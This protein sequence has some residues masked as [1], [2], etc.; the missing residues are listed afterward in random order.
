MK[1]KTIGVLLITLVMIISIG[2]ISAADT[3]DTLLGAVSDTNNPLLVEASDTNIATTSVALDYEDNATSLESDAGS[4][5]EINVNDNQDEISNQKVG[6]SSNVND[7]LLSAALN[8]DLL[9]ENPNFYY[10]EKGKWYGDLDDAVDDACDDGGGTILLTARAWG[11]DSAE[12]KITISDGVRITFQPYNPGDTVIFDGQGNE[13]WF[14]VI[15]DANAHVTFNN[16]TFR[17]GG[18]FQGGAIEV[19]HGSLTLDNCKFEN[20]KAY[21]NKAGGF[22]W[23]GAIFL[24]ESDASLIAKN[25]RFT[26]NNAASGGGAVYVEDGATATFNSCY[27]EGNKAAGSANHVQDEDSSSS[28]SFSDCQFIGSGSLDIDVEVTT[29]T[30]RITP[31]VNDDVNYAVLYK[32]GEVCGREPCNDGDTA[33]FD[34]LE[35]GTYTVYMMKNW[36]AKYEYPGNTFSLINPSFVLDGEQVFENLNAAVNAIPSGGSGVITVEGGTYTDPANFMVCIEDKTVTIMPK[37][38]DPLNP[39]IFSPDSIQ[40]FVFSVFP[41]GQLTME[42]ITMTGNMPSALVIYANRVCTISN[43]EFKNIASFGTLPGEPIYA[44]GANLVLDGNTFESNGRMYLEN[45]VVNIDDCTFTSNND[46]SNCQGGAIYADSSSNVTVTNSE[47]TYNQAFNDDKDDPV[48]VAKGGAI[49]A[50][51]LKVDNTE[52]IGNGAE[53]GA[54]IYIAGDSNDPVNITNCVFDSNVATKGY[55]HIYSESATRIFNLEFNEYDVNIKIDAKDGSY[56]EDYILEGDFDWGSNLD[57]NYTF[58]TGTIDDGDVVGDLVNIEDSRFKINIGVLSGGTHEFAIIGMFV[59]EDSNDYFYTH[60]YHSD[61]YGNQFYIDKDAYA[62]ILIDKAKITLTLDVNNVLIPETPVLNVEANWDLNYT[63]FIGNKYYQMEVKNGKGSMPLTGLDLGNYTVVAMRDSDENFYLAMNYT[64]FSISKTYSNFLVLSTNVEYDTLNEAVA[65]SNN[66]DTIYVK[67]G[68]YKN[69]GIVISNRTLDITALEGAI[70]DAQGGDANFIIVNENAIVDISGITFRGLHNRNTNYG[71]IVNHG[72]LTLTSCNFTDNKITKTSFAENGG[73]A[74]FNDGY[75][76][77]IDSCNFINNAAPLKVSTAAVTSVGYEDISITSSKFINNSAREGG[78]LHFKNISQFEAAII[79]C[80]FEQNTAVKGSAIYVGSNSRYLAVTSSSFKKNDIKNSLGENAQLEGGVI[81]VNANTSEVTFDI[82]LSNFENNSNRNVNGGVICLDGNSKAIIESCIFNNNSGK[83]GSVILIKNPYNKKLTLFVDD[84]NFINNH[85]TTGAIATS[86]RI[87]TLIDECVFADNTGENRNIYSNG[88]TVVHDSIFDVKDAK[89]NALSVQYGESSTISGTADVGT[90]LYAAA[91]LTVADDNVLVEIEN[92]TFT[93]KTD[94]LNHGKYYAVLNKISDNNNNTYL[95][96]SITEIFR[97]NN[98]ALDFGVSVDNITYGE[99]LKVVESIPSNATGTLDYQ[100]NGKY[101]TKEEIESL[102]LDAGKYTLVAVYDHEDFA[103]SSTTVDFEVYKANPT[104][105]VA[106]VEVVYGDSIIVNI[107]TNVPSIYT[108]EIDDYKTVKFINGSRF[109]EIEKTFEPGNYTIKVTSQERVNYISNFT[110]AILKV[111]KNRALFM[112]SVSNN[113]ADSDDTV[114]KVSAPDNAVGNIRYTVSDSNKNIVYTTTQ[115]C[116]DDLII[117]DLDDGT[118]E[119]NGVFEGDDLYYPTNNIQMTSLSIRKS[120]AD[121]NNNNI[122]EE[123][124][125]GRFMYQYD[126]DDDYSY[127][128]TLED[129]VDEAVLYGAGIITVRGGT[130]LVSSM[131]IEGEVELTI[132]A[133][134]DEEV[135]FDCGGDDYFM[136]LTY[137]EEVEWVTVPPPPHPETYQTDGP[138]VT[139]ENITVTGGKC[140]YGGAIDLRVGTLTLTNCNFINNHATVK[141]GAIYVG[142]WDGENDATLIALNTT[143]T[144]NYAE[145][146]G[147]AIYIADDNLDGQSTSASFMLCTFLDNY[148]GE[149]DERVRNYFGGE[150]KHI[151][152]QYCIFN[153]N[154]TI[155]NFEIDKINQTVYVNGTSTDVF[156]S[157]VLL[158]FNQAPLYSIDNK[159]ASDFNV[160]FEDVIGGNYTLG[161]MNDH[162]FNTYIFDVTFEMKVP[163]FIISEDEVY[164]NLTD[165]IDAVV[166][167]GIIYANVNYYTE[168]NMEIDIHKSFT[169][170]NFRDRDVVFDGSGEKWFFTIAEGNTVVFEGLYFTD[171]AVKTY[172]SIENNGNLIIKNCSFDS[173]ETS[174]IIHNTGL[175][176]ILNSTFSLNS[177]NNALVW[178][179]AT[180]FIETVE[181]SDNIVNISSAVYN[182]GAAEIVSSN[183]TGNYNGG[184]GGAIYSTNSLSVK[185]TVFTEN[186]GY[187]GGAI[188]SMG[189]LQVLNSTFEDNSANG[190]GGAIFNGN[191]ANIF[192]STFTGSSSEKDGGAIYNNHTMTINNSTFVGNTATGKGGAIYNN[193]SLNLTKSF[194]GINYAEEFANIYNAGDIQFSQN[195]FDFYD[196]VLIVPDGEYGIPT[197]ITGTLNPEFNMDIQVTLPEFVNNDDAQVTI[198]DGVFE[199]ITDPSLPKGIYPVKLNETIYDVY[200]NVYYGELISDRLIINKAN[201]YINVTVGDV[202]IRGAPGIPHLNI[203]A[204]QNGLFY[205][206][207]NNKLSNVTITD[208]HIALDL[209]AVGEGNYSVFVFREGNENYNDAINTTTFKVTEYEGNFIVNSTGNQSDTL[210]EAL[211]DSRPEDIIYVREGNYTGADNLG[212]SIY[213]KKLT[214]IALGDVVFNGDSTDLNFLTVDATADVTICDVVVSSF[215]TNNNRAIIENRGNLTL[216]GCVIVNNTCSKECLTIVYNSGNLNITGSEFYDNIA[217]YDNIAEYYIIQSDSGLII[218]ESTF[219][220]NTVNNA[221]IS[222]KDVEDSVKIISTEFVGNTLSNYIIDVRECSDVLISSEFYNNTK[223]GDELVDIIYAWKSTLLVENS[224]FI[225]NAMN[226]IIGGFSNNKNVISGC[227]FTDNAVNN[228]V[229]SDDINLSVI[230]SI[231]AGNTLSDNNALCI[232]ADVNAVTVNGCVFSDNKAD[233]YRNI[234]SYSSCSVNIANTTFDAINVDFTVRD[235]DYDENETINGTIDIGTNLNFTANLDINSKIYSVN[236]SDN[237]FTLNAGILNGGDYTV[238]LNPNGDNSNTYVFNKITKIFTVN[239]IDPGL[240]VSIEYIT[241]GEK[242]NVTS[243]IAKKAK[244]NVVYELNGVVY[245]KAQLENLTLNHGNYLVTA[246][247]RGDKNYLPATEIVNVN[248]NKVAPNI[249]VNDVAVNYGDEIKINVT[250]DVADYYTVFLDNRYNESVSLYVENSEIFTFPSEGFKPGSYNITVYVFETD[251]YA[252][253]YGNA[254]LTVN[255]AVGIF[256]IS[257][258][259]INYTENATIN[260][261]VPVNAYGNITYKVYDSDKEIVYNIT[262]SCLEELVVPNLSVGKYNVTG[263]FEGDSY[264]TNESIINFGVIEVNTKAVDLNITVSNITYTENATVIVE[265]DVDGKYLVYVGDNPYTVNVDSGKGNVTVPNLTVGNYTVNA[266][267]VDANYSAFNETVFNVTSKPVSVS[268]SIENIAYSEDA[269]VNVSAEVDGKYIVEIYNQKYPVNVVD[270]KGNTTVSDLFVD[271]NISASVSIADG[272][273][274]AYNTTTFNVT[275]KQVPVIISV[276]N[277]TYGDSAIVNIAAEIDGMYTLYANN[278]EYPINV[279]GGKASQEISGLFAENYTVQIA[280]VDGNYSAFNQTVFNVAPRPVSVAVS[281]K[282]ITYGENATVTVKADVDG[283]Y[284]V[285]VGDNPYTVNVVGGKGNTTVDGLT[286]G[287]YV[288]NV[289]VVDGNYSAVNFTSFDVAAKQIDVSVSVE[290]ITYG[291]G[292]LVVVVSDVDGEYIVEICNQNYTVNVAGGKGN[293]TVSDL[294]VGEDIL[295]SVSIADANYGAYNTT[296]FNVAPK[297]I[298][299]IISVGNI[300]YGEDA[301]VIVRSDVA[302]DYIVNI[303]GVNYIVSVNGGNG[304]KFIP[305]LDVGNQIAVSVKRDDNYTALNETAF[306]VNPKLGS[307]SVSVEDITYGENAIANIVAEID[308]MYTLSV[309]NVEYPINVT[310]GKASQ[311]ISGL[312]VEDYVAQIAIVDGN[313]SAFNQTAFYVAPR[314][315]S[316]V[317]S[318]E[319]ITYEEDAVVI[320][321]ADVDGEYLV[322][323][324]DDPYVVIVDDGVGGIAVDALAV[325]SYA[326]SVTVVDGNYSAVNF[327]SFDVEVKEIDVSVSVEDITYGESALVFVEAD[328]DGEYLVYVGDDPYVVIVDDGVGGIAVDALAVGSYAVG[329]TVVDGNYSAVNFTS[330]DVEV[331]EIDVSVSVDDITYGEKAVVI[332]E[333]DVDGEYLVYVGDDPYVVIVDD[334]VGGI[335]VDGL[336]VGSY[337]VGV[338][339]VDG[340]YSGFDSTSFDVEVKEID[341]SVSVENITY[342]EKAVVIVVS[343]IDGEY[344]VYVGDDPYV[345]I[346]D[347]GVG[348]IAVGGLAVGSHVASVTVVDGNYSGFDSTSF[349]VTA[350]PKPKENATISIDAPAINEGENATVTVTL[351]KDA[352]GIVAIGDELVI[353]ENGTAS[354]VLTNLPV[355]YTN[356]SIAYSGDDKYNPI[357]TSAVVTVYEK[358][359]P[360]KENLTISAAANPITVGEDAT[361]VVS[362]LKDATGEV[363]ITVN[364]KS[365]MAPIVKGSASVNVPGL[366]KNVTAEVSYV[367]DAKYNGASTSVDI[368]VNPKPKENATI[369]IDAPKEVTEGDNVTVTVTLPSDATGTV[370]IGND[371][372]PVVKGTASAV[373]TN[374]PVGNNTVPITYSGDDKYNPI[375]T[376]VTVNVKED[377]SDIIKAPDVTKYYHGSERF[378]VTVTDYQGNPIAN[379]SVAIVING[380]SYTKTTDAN[381][382]TS[383][384]L[385]LGSGV[386]NATA[387]VDNTTI[388]SVITI[389][390]TVNGTDL[391]KVFRNDTQ[392]YAT[393][394]DSNGNYLAEGT[395]VRFNI[396]GVMYDR[397]ISGDKGLAKLNIN[398]PDGEYIITAMNPETGEMASNNITVLPR[399]VDNHDLTKYY[400]NASQYTVKLIGDDGNPVGAGEKVTYN[401]N[402]V[403]YTRTTNASGIAELNINLIP[404]DYIITAEYKGY[405]VSNNIKVLPTL[406]GKDVTKKYGQDGAFE[407]K[408]V[409]GQGK[410]YAGQKIEFNINGVFY[411]KTTNNNGIAKLNI[412]LQ[413]G[414]YIVTSRYGQAA[415]SNKVTVT[416]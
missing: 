375:E 45:T 113:V 106:D 112:L 42:H 13:Y 186:E 371:V 252:E 148:Q 135:I 268:I 354:A 396:N 57:N 20:N 39:V 161:V 96:D 177:V 101:Y 288:A 174:E 379:K 121:V 331:K 3:N 138:T 410:P 164:E 416:A 71:A 70:F 207:F 373:L 266:T 314:P 360:S 59:Q 292:A 352:T 149:D 257:D 236:V 244:G 316:L 259:S 297:Q 197:T 239:R 219:E 212:L 40:N 202:V 190:Y 33:T 339:V 154:G 79:S 267:A 46:Y 16:I 225:G 264:Y 215:N 395:S 338:T 308:G 291:E 52:F 180:L 273:Y 359:V 350:S 216:D 64:N 5:V 126:E 117:P 270:G 24:D 163:N 237:K 275:P 413:P 206:L 170:K 414:E 179:D 132:R 32:N 201:V 261:E 362:G 169:L 312:F 222:I 118:Y 1:K 309:N 15:D 408:L 280:I 137:G 353:V 43:C 92:N 243:T 248:V 372:V 127:F 85:A 412:N 404:G 94:I 349:E 182:N 300:T 231:F 185:D 271:E 120:S 249:T 102:N 65:N 327:T 146:E 286:V 184:N 50:S 165:A 265:A 147:G 4:D 378:V 131:D 49:Y 347:D 76:L 285:Y 319:N 278:V 358:P 17:N 82:D 183:F 166:E 250:V 168:D 390:T 246:V 364:G 194:F 294:F 258:D 299:V 80:D 11:Y 380:K 334:G 238:V 150:T 114:I 361:I 199:Y 301:V 326:V 162:N 155:Y 343:E 303:R 304:V 393:F 232:A 35:K 200:G 78:A 128:D 151:T 279:T 12:R 141:G 411:T 401:I 196:V 72:Y 383:V 44:I 167:N 397:K 302:G 6:T 382:T 263:T 289:T 74:I 107:E 143:F 157:V 348:G 144:N 328:V 134:G 2:A 68:T 345:V 242:L 140:R 108:I 281:V 213:S 218:N 51:K 356:V 310:G 100:L 260:V 369:S 7:D 86:P 247:Y 75:S 293:T 93:Y 255:K 41:N 178:N 139:L 203:D 217:D 130:Y 377:K 392:Y 73:A 192:N 290:D 37:D 381:G 366:T 27:F 283:E 89:L 81:Y 133:Y 58:F 110:E 287:S 119:I 272:N 9:G 53:L 156:D 26:N 284:L 191:E 48:K 298:P 317:V 311:I 152:S 415:L 205:I 306:N 61:L 189:I 253:A 399:I 391:V 315:V 104:I 115:S 323:V 136:L 21:K 403:F 224:I 269:I 62:E 77:E 226:A 142:T 337:A 333:A 296:T 400:R 228:V 103:F 29:N 171:G 262:Q 97:V 365:Y 367:G 91:N 181:F 321:E 384:G 116:S 122:G 385:N 329:V 344:L 307:V 38:Y 18:A 387:T 56:G 254:T 30:V 36:E 54:A 99:T 233:N 214:I 98:V 87:T 124:D 336:T 158:Y 88:F 325:G 335:A 187:D 175:L 66:D 8:D 193:G 245:S 282:N 276:E 10:K 90:N 370:T 409:D 251:D 240:S 407:A 342:G 55:R 355:G 153:G 277:I 330:F 305:N 204:S 320:V 322:Y 386:Y 198:S 332:V 210:R 340:N 195:I 221:I 23:G 351:P 63:I 123:E 229:F 220:N 313:Y 84:S 125:E 47:F 295:A 25:C 324:G 95:M 235:I 346:V 83:V 223:C 129:A 389:L 172:A 145:D 406:T 60:R 19:V 363:A 14:F 211:E 188:Y 31:D 274:S 318:V 209:E 374:L 368:V 402:G 398:L 159:G 109:V 256:N 394:R 405:K 173:F 234:Y 176:N 357:E 241:E 227:V 376:G 105:S 34:N 22:G 28:H 341:V 230:D 208:G 388:H 67:K 160:T 111:N 69:T